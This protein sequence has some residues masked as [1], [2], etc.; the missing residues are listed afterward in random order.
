MPVA[1][2]VLYSISYV[3]PGATG[4]TPGASGSARGQFWT[5]S[6]YG[7]CLVTHK[8][9]RQCNVPACQVTTSG[10][11]PYLFWHMATKSSVELTLQ[12]LHRGG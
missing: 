12:L 7:D 10:Y 11:S 4:W 2:L 3:S 9:V 5:L 8:H 1:A 6:K